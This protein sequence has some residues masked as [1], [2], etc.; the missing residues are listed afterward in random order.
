MPPSPCIT[1][2]PDPAEDTRLRA[3]RQCHPG[4]AVRAH[5]ARPWHGLCDRRHRQGAPRQLHRRAAARRRNRPSPRARRRRLA[6]MTHNAAAT[7]DG[8]PPLGEVI[9]S[10]AL[11]GAQEPRAKLHPRS[12]PDPPHCPCRRRAQ[13]SH[14]GRDRP[15]PGRAH[16]RAAAGGGRARPSHRNA[17]SAAARRWR[18]SPSVTPVVSRCVSGCAQDAT[19]RSSQP[20]W[21]PTDR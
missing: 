17:T 20:T 4:A 8:L 5:L 3:R 9:R 7:P 19:G 11:D 15:G 13:R 1:T 10:L 6:P 12:Q 16:A 18:P 21:H 14:G 2:R